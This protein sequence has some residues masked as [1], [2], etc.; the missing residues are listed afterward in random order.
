MRAINTGDRVVV[1]CWHHLYTGIHV[2]KNKH[3]RSCRHYD[4]GELQNF[5][6]LGAWCGVGTRSR[7][8]PDSP[9]YIMIIVFPSG[10]L[11]ETCWHNA[12]AS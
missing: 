8:D 11:H 7:T 10:I 12:D 2:P 3:R 4:L 9:S 6:Q 1:E 5:T